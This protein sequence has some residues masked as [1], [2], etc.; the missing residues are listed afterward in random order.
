MPVRYVPPVLL[1]FILL[2]LPSCSYAACPSADPRHASTEFRGTDGQT[3]QAAMS[4]MQAGDTERAER[5]LKALHARYPQS[6]ALNEALGLLYASASKP[7]DAAPFLQ[8]AAIICPDSSIAHA[9]LGVAY[10]NLQQSD[11]AAKELTRANVLE[12]GNP[13]TAE[14]LGEA[15][16]QLKHW[17]QATTAFSSALDSDTSDQD[18]LY[19]AALANF[20][21]GQY[22]KTK[23]LLGRMTGLATSA[24]A[25]SLLG[26]VEEKLGNYQQAGQHYGNAVKLDPSEDNLY[27][28]AIEFL[29]HWTFAP[30]IQNFSIG[31]R[32]FPDSRR[33]QFGLAIAYYGNENYDLAIKTLVK[34]LA[35]EPDNVKYADLLGRACT[36]PNEGSNPECDT[37]AEFAKRHP[38]DA[39][40]ATYAAGN[41]L[42]KPAGQQD[43]DGASKLLQAALKGAPKSPETQY[44]MGLLLQTQ[45]KWQESVAPLETA[46]RLQPDY[47]VAHYRLARAYSR[48][49]R[50]EEAKRE[51]DQ[52]QVY[53]KKNEADLDARMKEIT[54]LVTKIQ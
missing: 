16:M 51:I 38:Q 49:G 28:L 45:S 29:R 54:T 35:L 41:M 46:I 4:A 12:P 6:F 52:Y 26:D 7:A 14:A 30:A 2:F 22:A 42:H 39:A 33:M 32:D 47:A 21:T 20:N 50:A 27:L 18:L 53:N 40:A 11:K 25:Q 19:N 3:F 48:L 9:N 13:H 5:S 43:L 24:P 10:L 15:E 17:N 34:L 1:F 23:E 31:V 36:T 37:L 44:E 8:Q